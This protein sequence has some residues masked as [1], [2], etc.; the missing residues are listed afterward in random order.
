M[1]LS[2]KLSRSRKKTERLRV[3]IKQ[4]RA[5]R[6]EREQGSEGTREELQSDE[7]VQTECELEE[8]R[9]VCVCVCVCVWCDG[10]KDRSP[11][12]LLCLLFFW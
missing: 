10:P 8:R 4:Q 3:P 7:S 9:K 11:C 12:V 1:K 2:V 6:G 5:R